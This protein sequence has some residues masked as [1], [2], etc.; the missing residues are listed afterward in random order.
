[1]T[2]ARD[3][4]DNAQN[5]KPKVVDAKGDLIVGT[6]ADTA[7]RLAVGTDGHLLT[8]ASGEATG[9][10]FALDPVID[11]VTTKGDI[12]AAT[13][14]DTLTR[15]GVGANGTVLTAASGEATGLQW[16]APATGGGYTVLGTYTADNTTATATFSTISGAY[17]ELYIVGTGLAQGGSNTNA[18]ITMQFNSDT[19]ANYAWAATLGDN[20]TLSQVNAGSTTSIVMSNFLAGDGDV[21]MRFGN[22]QMR[23]FDYSSATLYKS[24][25]FL[26]GS[27]STGDQIE[28]AGY[29]HWNNTDAITSVS[30]TSSS[31]NF[32][33]G[34]IQLVGVN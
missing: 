33:V 29:G 16:A 9:L 12:V 13:A 11:V 19:G 5:T 23:I 14:A 17:K 15:L 10:I 3:L 30:M 21:S 6:A 8:A 31:G 22:F 28:L 4:G 25:Q 18:N 1:M 27:R 24:I 20:G 32:R 26:A 2:K 34:T 7:A